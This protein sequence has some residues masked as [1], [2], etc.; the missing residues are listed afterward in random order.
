MLDFFDAV[1]YNCLENELEE[2]YDP[3]IFMQDGVW[4]TGRTNTHYSQPNSNLFA[5]Y[6]FMGLNFVNL[7]G[8]DLETAIYKNLQKTASKNIKNS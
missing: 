3:I 7:S 8:R 5:A 6:G 4:L 1:C 2:R